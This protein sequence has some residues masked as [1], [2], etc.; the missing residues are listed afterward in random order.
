MKRF[1]AVL[2]CFLCAI[3]FSWASEARAQNVENSYFS[4]G[5]SLYNQ[6]KYEEAISSYI[7]S[8]QQAPHSAKKSYLNCARAYSML[9]NYAASNQYYAFYQEVAPEGSSDR[10]FKAEY[11]AM[12]RKARQTPYVRDASQTTVLRQV[13]QMLETGGVFWNRQGNGILAYYDVLMRSG[14]AEPEL[15]T[16]QRQ[17]VA[18]LQAELESNITPP[19]GQPL[20][21]LD[22]T[23]WVY[24]RNKIEKTRRFQDVPPDETKLRAIETTALAWEAFYRGDY[25][26][27][28]KQFDEACQKSPR[29]PAA[30]WGR[31]MLSFQLEKN[32]VLLEQIDE[33]EKVYQESHIQDVAHYF[34]LLR[35]QV[36]RNLDNLN[37]SLKWLDIMQ[38][39][40]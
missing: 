25:E 39:A 37:E 31:V 9:K 36:Y 33:A 15:Y 30:F 7:K 16:I 13:K 27:A 18:G 23:G 8:I 5:N 34:A 3:A 35:A 14:F 20:P 32:D 12:K 22:R 24:I 2:F 1:Y 21:N 10:K 28:N 26:V 19:P 6:K 11:D 38:G 4:Q 17:I 40:L 29:L